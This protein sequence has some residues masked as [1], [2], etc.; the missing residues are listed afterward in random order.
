MYALALAAAGT[1]AAGTAAAA[2]VILKGTICVTAA[3]D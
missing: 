3:P 1:A 2:T